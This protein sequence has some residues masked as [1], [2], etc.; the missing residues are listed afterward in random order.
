MY[1][2]LF[3]PTSKAI[4]E[5][6]LQGRKS[7]TELSTELQLSKSVLLQKYL[8][9]FESLGLVT[10]TVEKTS[11]GRQ[12]YYELNGFTLHFS[13][14]PSSKCALAF[15]TDLDLEDH[16]FLLGQVKDVRFR[17]DLELLLEKV[18]GSDIDNL[19]VHIILYGSVA[20]EE[21]SDRSDIDLAFVAE[22]WNK[23]GK[24]AI[25][26]L[27][28]ELSPDIDHVIRPVFITIA[29]ILEADN[30]L[31]VEIRKTGKIIYGERYQGTGIWEK[32]ETYRNITI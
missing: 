9:T 5:N 8:S 21:A 11:S 24:N 2:L 16:S 30:D 27:I 1:D 10:K 19:F 18:A 26:D 32:M 20:K 13:I 29:D 31:I 7:L 3:K 6:L 15:T 23:Q 4:I 14:D 22:K 25:I 12:A 17:D 28:S